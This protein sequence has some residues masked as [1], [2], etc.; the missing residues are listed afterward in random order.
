MKYLI[1]T[2]RISGKEWLQYHPHNDITPTDRYYITLCNNVLKLIQHSEISSFTNVLKKEKELACLLVAYFE[3]VISETRLFSTFTRLHKKMYGQELPFYKIPDDYYDDE[4][5]LHDIYFLI[6]YYISLQNE[7]F[8]I[9]PYFK[10]SLNFRKAISK[11]YELFDREFEKAPQ[12]E[13]LQ[14]ILRLSANSNVETVREKLLFIAYE[15]FLWRP[16]FC[17]FFEDLLDKYREKG[18]VVLDEQSNVQIYDSRIHFVFNEYMPLLAMRANEYFAEILGEE[19]SEY[20]FIKNIS[21]RIF[22]SFLIQKIESNGF[23]LEHLSSKKQLWLSNEFTSLE[24]IKLVENETVLSIGLVQWKDDI[25]QN[26]G[27]CMVSTIKEM[28]G[29]DTSPH[30]FDDEN[31]KKDV[32]SNLE[33]AFLEITNGKRIIYL[34]GKREFSDINLKVAKKHAKM[35]NPEMTDREIDQKHKNLIKNSAENIP[36]DDKEP[37]AIFFNSNSGMEVYLEGA[38]SCMPDTNNPHYKHE[39]FDLCDL[40]TDKTLSKEFVNYVI[41][42]KLINLDISGCGTPETFDAIMGNLDFLLRF[43]RRAS[44]FSK[45]EVTIR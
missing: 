25:W 5:N 44:Y 8:V 33:K 21:E 20:Q 24:G 38:V 13:N 43:Y 16:I 41:E 29:K 28:K 17:D 23:L 31:K 1:Q 39:E 30:I 27:G 10:N 22:G 40:I 37:I 3:D 14:D 6:W 7:E 2:N 9:D 26:Q 34:Y 19:H 36:F 11:I 35:M 42:N 32:I 4:I 12:N 18:V 45:P 15:S